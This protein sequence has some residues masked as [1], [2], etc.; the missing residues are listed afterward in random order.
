MERQRF[1]WPEIISRWAASLI[2][3]YYEDLM[4]VALFDRLRPLSEP[5]D[6][7]T[8][9]PRGEAFGGAVQDLAQTSRKAQ[10]GR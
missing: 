8:I 7:V 9:V 1:R 3:K 4:L 5:D 6:G 2:G 10:T